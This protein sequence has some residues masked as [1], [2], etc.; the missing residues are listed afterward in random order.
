[1]KIRIPMKISRIT[2]HFNMLLSFS[3]KFAQALGICSTL[4]YH[5]YVHRLKTTRRML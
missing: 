2:V 1:M 4:Y 3:A 5:Y